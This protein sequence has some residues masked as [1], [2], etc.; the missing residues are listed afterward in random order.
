MKELITTIILVAIV[1]IQIGSESC[2]REWIKKHKER[3]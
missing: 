2:V 1:S 3:S